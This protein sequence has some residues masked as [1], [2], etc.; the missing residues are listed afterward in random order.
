MVSEKKVNKYVENYL[1]NSISLSSDEEHKKTIWRKVLEHI[2][3][4]REDILY[5]KKD[6]DYVY[7]KKGF[8]KINFFGI[9]FH[10]AQLIGGFV[11]EQ[12]IRKRLNQ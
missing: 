12:E 4:D 9:L 3:R 2:Y 7:N 6:G 5:K 8:K 1:D 10:L 11:A